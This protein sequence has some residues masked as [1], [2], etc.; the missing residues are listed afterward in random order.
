L[1]DVKLKYVQVLCALKRGP[2]FSSYVYINGTSRKNWISLIDMSSIN[3]C[4]MN[5]NKINLNSTVS[6][7]SMQNCKSKESTDLI[8]AINSLNSSMAI[9][10]VNSSIVLNFLFFWLFLA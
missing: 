10:T 2:D 9:V 8:E 1:K 6:F 3:I 7:L 4:T 5:T